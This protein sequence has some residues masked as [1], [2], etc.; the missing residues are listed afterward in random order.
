MYLNVRVQDQLHRALL[1]YGAT[2]CFNDQDLVHTMGLRTVPVP[3]MRVALGEK[4]SE[5]LVNQA[6]ITE[7]RL[8]KGVRYTAT[9]YVM[10]LGPASVILGQPFYSDLQL[11]VDYG[12]ARTVTFP[13]LATGRPNVTLPALPSPSQRQA[14]TTLAA[15][16]ESHLKGD[17]RRTLQAGTPVSLTLIHLP[18]ECSNLEWN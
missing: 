3:P 7:L 8:A 5:A 1:D 4:D 12:P 13:S 10:P 14:V 15:V 16:T 11:Q 17:L 6:V 2:S 9:L 18:S